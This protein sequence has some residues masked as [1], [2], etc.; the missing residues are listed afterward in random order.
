MR[1]GTR[2]N[3]GLVVGQVISVAAGF[4]I[5]ASAARVYRAGCLVSLVIG[6]LWA[7]A[8][9]AIYYNFIG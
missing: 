3:G 5:G 4:L 9:G 8:A 1:V 7:I 6:L 2:S